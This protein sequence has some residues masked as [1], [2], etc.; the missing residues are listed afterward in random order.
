MFTGACVAAIEVEINALLA[1]EAS[2]PII[3]VSYLDWEPVCL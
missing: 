3:P 1:R 2:N